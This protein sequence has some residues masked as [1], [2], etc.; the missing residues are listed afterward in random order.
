MP[1]LRLPSSLLL[2]GLLQACGT[3]APPL[4]SPAAPPSG[5][6]QAPD[7]ATAATR[8]LSAVAPDEPTPH[9]L[10]LAPDAE[11]WVRWTGDP[12]LRPL[13][14]ALAHAPDGAAADARLARARALRESAEAQ[15]RPQFGLEL[16]ASEQSGPLVNAAG[17]QGRLLDAR[18]QWRADLDLR[19]TAERRQ[20]AAERDEAA[21][22]AQRAATRLALQA[23][24]VRLRL[25]W[26]AL[27]ADEALR[28]RRLE[29]SD[30]LLAL[31]ERRVRAG[32]DAAD[33]IERLRLDRE[34]L[35]REQAR[36]GE[37]RARLEHALAA[38]SGQAPAALRMP[39]VAAPAEL[40]SP[41][42]PAPAQL[43]AQRPDVGAAWAR[44]EAAHR[45]W[46]AAQAG[47]GLSLGLNAQA[48]LAGM[49]LANLALAAARGGGLAALL[50]LPLGDGG[51]Q[52]AARA[53]AQAELDLALA[54]HEAT[55]LRALREVEDRLA[56]RDAAL[57]VL[58]A[59]ERQRE[60][61]ARLAASAVSRAARGLA[62]EADALRAALAA[63]QAEAD[64]L[65]AAQARRLA[66]VDLAEA[67]AGPGVDAGAS[68]VAA[69]AAADDRLDLLLPRTPRVLP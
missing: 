28:A 62:S 65:R 40:A 27:A 53:G 20:E 8:P 61:H 64:W 63:S 2:A 69:G 22:L 1:R 33:P 32:F 12:G 29:Q 38:L 56:G 41:A 6:R 42:L 49:R 68:S 19:G 9:P 39:A 37:A 43:L 25:A 21:S 54:E 51:R 58:A 14:A 44:A 10:P 52:A 50:A 5:W 59:S 15:R 66:E 34:A 16:A 23:E 55:R 60:S 31:A 35:R 57:G 48:G 17:T 36:A 26:N 7:A 47:D 30:R 3:P 11:A 46:V 18:L 24:T 45:R 67:L 13:L 4:A